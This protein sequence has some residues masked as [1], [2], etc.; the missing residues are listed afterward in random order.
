MDFLLNNI[1]EILV[2]LLVLWIINR[3]LTGRTGRTGD[4]IQQ[5]II[6]NNRYHQMEGGNFTDED[7]KSLLPGQKILAV[8][9]VRKRYGLGLKESLTYVENI[10]HDLLNQPLSEKIAAEAARDLGRTLDGSVSDELREKVKKIKDDGN[11][12]EA[13]KTLREGVDLDLKSAKGY[14]DQL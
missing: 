10:Q 8:M 2:V 12:I 1:W 11:E 7:L 9:L 14:V 4:H 13:I 6:S 5:E 3:V